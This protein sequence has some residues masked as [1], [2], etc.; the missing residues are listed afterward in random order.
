LQRQIVRLRRFHRNRSNLNWFELHLFKLLS[1][2]TIKARTAN[3]TGAA[4]M[5]PN[6]EKLS[7]RNNGKQASTDRCR[8]SGA[9]TNPKRRNSVL[10]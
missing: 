2:G 9:V 7:Q 3:P 5:C 4:S 8:P 6:Q 10:I 1:P